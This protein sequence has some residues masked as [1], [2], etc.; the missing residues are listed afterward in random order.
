MVHET[1]KAESTASARALP[2]LETILSAPDPAH[3]IPHT[4]RLPAP[5]E[6][7]LFFMLLAPW[8][9]WAK[10]PGVDWRGFTIPWVYS[11]CD[12]L[13]ARPALPRSAR[14]LSWEPRTNTNR[15]GEEIEWEA[16][17]ELPLRDE[18]AQLA[19]ILTAPA[20]VSLQ[21]AL[22]SPLFATPVA[23]FLVR[24]F[25]DDGIDEFL[26]HITTLEAALGVLE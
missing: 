4:S 15:D 20:W 8:E 16:P 24:A 22:A 17:I 21:N 3:I 13:F 9:D 25:L 23:H 11:R 19:G 2:G 1:V 5:V 7:A 26:A 12:D 10:M 14:S 18:A 6:Q